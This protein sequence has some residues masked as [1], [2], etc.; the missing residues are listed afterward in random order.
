MPNPQ[1]AAPARP[2]WLKVIRKAVPVLISMTLVALALSFT[3]RK[4]NSFEGAAGFPRGVVHGALSPMALPNLVVGDNVPIYAND[5]TGI[6]Y[7]IGFS[8]GINLC[9]L[10]FFSVLYFR[11]KRLRRQLAELKQ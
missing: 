2:F 9:G 7:K 3:L 1:I 8:L 10:F 5:N 11:L 6:S 4:L